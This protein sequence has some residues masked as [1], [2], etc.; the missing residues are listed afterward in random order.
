VD[1]FLK[2]GYPCNAIV[3]CE[4]LRYEHLASASPITDKSK[5]VK[6]YPVRVLL[7]GDYLEEATRKLLQ[8][9]MDSL[10]H[11][12]GIPKFSIKPHP[13]SPVGPEEC[14][15]LS[16]T[17]VSGS[18]KELLSKFDIVFSSNLTSAS[19]DAYL[20]DLPVIVMN[21][22]DELNF[23][24]LREKEGVRFVSSGK[25]LA[26]AIEYFG[27]KRTYND[28]RP[29]FFFMDNDLSRWNQ[30]ISKRRI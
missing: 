19:V 20:S 18:F 10:S 23:S 21:A 27:N 29:N 2:A 9:A 17:V 4:A 8:L 15:R 11:L 16:L 30:I 28:Y 26:S 22:D 7:L 1:A 14:S 24:P 3:E 5:R 6:P 12:R 25:A 13:N